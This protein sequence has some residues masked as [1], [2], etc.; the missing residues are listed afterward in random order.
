M[1][2]GSVGEELGKSG[3][4]VGAGGPP[5][6]G[7]N[8]QAARPPPATTPA[9]AATA[10]AT[11]APSVSVDMIVVAAVGGRVSPLISTVVGVKVASNGE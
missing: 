6:I 1:V 10:K 3:G 5:T 4:E 8:N 2:L 7:W 11:V 9:P